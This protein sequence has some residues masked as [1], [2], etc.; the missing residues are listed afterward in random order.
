MLR[1]EGLTYCANGQTSLSMRSTWL[2][3]ANSTYY[4]FLVGIR[5]R[6]V[7]LGKEILCQEP[8]TT[9]KEEYCD[10]VLHRTLEL[11]P[12]VGASVLRYVVDAGR[13]RSHC[14]IKYHYRSAASAVKAPAWC[15]LCMSTLIRV[16][17]N[18]GAFGRCYKEPGGRANKL[19]MSGQNSTSWW[20][21]TRMIVKSIRRG[22]NIDT[23]PIDCRI[24]T[25]QKN[26]YPV[27]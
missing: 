17:R 19:D 22:T 27:N 18:T 11:H 5:T 1:N 20:R 24:G 15:P 23:V 13:N 10:E 26:H 6:N 4:H 8:T 9:D 3:V 25:L 2:T 16:K 12:G 21:I 7:S 14:M